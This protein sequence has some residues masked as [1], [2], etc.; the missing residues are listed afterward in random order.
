MSAVLPRFLASLLVSAAN[1]ATC[2]LAAIPPAQGASDAAGPAAG[3]VLA[4]GAGPATANQDLDHDPTRQ[5]ATANPG[6]GPPP[7][8]SPLLP[9][10]RRWRPRPRPSPSLSLNPD[11][12]PR[13]S[14]HPP[15]ES[16]HQDLQARPSLMQRMEAE[17]RRSHNR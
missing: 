10:T 12:G 8:P 6:L 15:R 1:G 11:P 4:P 9:R 2:V 7:D 3:A 17:P 16:L 5:P 14:P 13:A